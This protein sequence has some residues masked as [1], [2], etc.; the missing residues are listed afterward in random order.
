MDAERPYNDEVSLSCLQRFP[1]RKNYEKGTDLD[2]TK[3][4]DVGDF[5][6]VLRDAQSELLQKGAYGDKL[7]TGGIDRGTGL[8]W[9]IC[10]NKLYI[11]SYLS[12]APSNK[13][14]TVEIP[15]MVFENS[16]G[17]TKERCANLWMVCLV[18]WDAASANSA[19]A[20]GQCNSAGVV[21]CNMRTHGLAYWPDIF[22][23]S[24]SMPVISLP[25]SFDTDE[26]IFHGE[27]GKGDKRDQENTLAGSSYFSDHLQ[28][29]SIVAAPVTGSSDECIAIACQSSGKLWHFHFTPTRINR[30]KVPDDIFGAIDASHPQ[31]NKRYARSLIWHLQPSQCSEKSDHRFFLLTDSEVQC[32]NAILTPV[33]DVRKF[34]THE[35]ISSVADMGIKKDLAGQKHIWLLDMQVDSRGK[36]ITILVATFCKDRLG[37]SS[38]T[39]YS[40]LTML[41]KDVKNLTIEN[42]GAISARFLEKKAPLQI[43]IPKARV[44]DEDFLFSMRLRVG[45]KPAGSAIVLSGDGTATVTH[46]IRGCTRLYQFDLPYDAGKVLDASVFPSAEDDE[47]GAWIV[48]TEKVGVWAVPEKAVL[49]GGVEPP[50]RSLSRKGSCNEGVAQEEKRIQ[51]FVGN[52]AP[53]R[54]SSEAWGSGDRPRPVITSMVQRVVQD[55]E[56]D[57]LLGRLFHDFMLSGE[58]DGVLKS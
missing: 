7:F 47:E 49:L 29:N 52:M 46:Y 22:S 34:W 11:W 25:N 4:V 53:R 15:S 57:A 5:P 32:W 54:A 20:L 50:E 13:C 42:P 1:T 10:R 24:V 36:E 51:A 43:I 16:G 35:I 58:I 39:Q 44:E 19:N 12:A 2:Q 31:A 37:G 56:A 40:L 18:K 6:S 48:L 30:K 28:I 21:I 41:Y 17:N 14:V 3:P 33:V 45:G 38:Y 9:M 8:C 23:E 55:E 27:V 26:I